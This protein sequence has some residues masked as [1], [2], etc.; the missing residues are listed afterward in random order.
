MV[1]P[2][3]MRTA[4]R[5]SNDQLVCCRAMRIFADAERACRAQ[6]LPVHSLRSQPYQ[7]LDFASFSRPGIWARLPGSA[8]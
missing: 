4:S 5:T 8:V 2:A 6:P 3:S 1:T 7:Q